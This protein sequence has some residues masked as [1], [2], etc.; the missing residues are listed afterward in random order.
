MK[1]LTSQTYLDFGGE[2]RG[3]ILD[4]SSQSWGVYEANLNQVKAFRF[5]FSKSRCIVVSWD[6]VKVSIYVLC[7]QY[8]QKKEYQYNTYT[9]I[10]FPVFFSFFFSLDVR[11]IFTACHWRNSKFHSKAGCL[12]RKIGPRILGSQLESTVWFYAFYFH[13]FA[14]IIFEIPFE[15]CSS[16][17]NKFYGQTVYE[18]REIFVEPFSST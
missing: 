14:H 17:R 16:K 12:G 3:C 10:S 2:G 1:N 8:I 5:S 9:T 7:L 18:R 15:P 6:Q 13:P 11:A 4:V